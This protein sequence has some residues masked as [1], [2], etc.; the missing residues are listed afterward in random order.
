MKGR[1]YL[2]VFVKKQAFQLNN[3]RLLWLKNLI[4]QSAFIR[5][6]FVA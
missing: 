2:A 3:V 4:K 5:L 6:L 1:L